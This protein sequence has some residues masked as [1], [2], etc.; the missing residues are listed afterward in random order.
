MQNY[1]Y[2]KHFTIEEAR[3]LV[4]ELRDK[5]LEIRRITLE[6]KTIGFDIYTGKYKPGF[7]PDTLDEYPSNYLKL[8]G[9]IKGITEQGIEL[10]ALEYGLVDFPS[11]RENGEEVFLCWKMDEDDIEY[12]HPIPAGFKGREHIRNF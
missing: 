5:L 1:F 10:K 7:H 11:L 9:T 6:L 3:K 4:P 12:W 2:D 8:I